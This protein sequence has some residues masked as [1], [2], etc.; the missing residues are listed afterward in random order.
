MDKGIL[1]HPDE[2]YNYYND[3]KCRYLSD[4]FDSKKLTLVIAPNSGCNFECPYCFEEK[5]GFKKMGEGFNENIVKF[6]NSHTEAKTM[7]LVWYGGEPLLSFNRIREIYFSIKSKTD[8][9]ITSHSIITNG[10]LI[11]DE[12]L[13]FFKESHLN[14]I[15]IT[16]DGTEYTHNKTR[17]LRQSN[18][19][20]YKTIVSNIL[21]TAKNL[22][23]CNV[24]VRINISKKNSEDFIVLSNYFNST[25]LKNIYPYPGFVRED[26]PDKHSL[27]SISLVGDSAASYLMSLK[28]KRLKYST[29]P[30]TTVKGCMVNHINSY[31]IGPEGELYK[32]WNDFNNPSKVIGSIFDKELLNKKLFHS[33]L[34]ELSA[35]SD[36]KCKDC[37]FFPICSGGCSWYRYRNIH[38]NGQFKICYDFKD[39]KLFEQ[40]LINTYVK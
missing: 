2:K 18:K 11:N 40:H 24:S 1:T 6:I 19:P 31:I 3:Q 26:T 5:K 17:Y 16:L 4:S 30:H 27:C 39:L 21:K 32:C 25:E 29:S 12:I 22:P 13:E 20:T 15:Q 10:Y 9:N 34:L 7:N 33:Y 8:I 37:L 14:K 28:D 35:F 36:T 23:T 38:E